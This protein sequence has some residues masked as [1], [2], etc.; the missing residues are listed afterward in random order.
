MS[1]Q[2]IVN[3]IAAVLISG[4]LAVIIVQVLKRE[5]WPSWAR[6]VLG[7]VVALLVGVAQTWVS[8]DL[9]GLIHA[10]GSLTSAQVIAWAAAVYAASQVWYHTY[11]GGTGWMVGLGLWPDR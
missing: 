5:F 4:P 7:L 1:W 8:G 10:W 3:L 2:E 6:A 11:L 9:L